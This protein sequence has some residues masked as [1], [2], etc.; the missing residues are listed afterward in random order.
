MTI[1][2]LPPV[3]ADIQPAEVDLLVTAIL[4]RAGLNAEVIPDYSRDSLIRAVTRVAYGITLPMRPA[5]A[6]GRPGRRTGRRGSARGR[7]W[8]S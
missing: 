1:A 2:V 4:L 8:R 3:P 6:P 5:G 7:H